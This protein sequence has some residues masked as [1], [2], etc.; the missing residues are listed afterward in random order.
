MPSLLNQLIYKET[1]K[2]FEENS[3]LIFV[4]YNTFNQEDAIEIRAAAKAVEGTA[5][6]VKNAV[7]AI[8]LKDM[9]IDGADAFLKGP[10]LV[11][12][13]N[14]PVAMSKVAAD[15][16]KKAKNKKGAPLGGIVDGAIVSAET[17][18][19][20]SKI[21]TRQVLLGMLVNV[22][23]SPMRGLAVALNAIKEKNEQAV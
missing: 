1:R 9:G 7:S 20:L 12:M 8:V 22:I 15:F 21:P 2:S 17:V 14:D 13:G 10:A 11:I 16:A 19:A 23:S 6:V 4:N 3:A 5:S 18:M